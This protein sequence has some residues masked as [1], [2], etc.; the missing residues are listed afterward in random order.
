MKHAYTPLP[1]PGIDPE[2]DNEVKKYGLHPLPSRTHMCQ[3]LASCKR[4]VS[5]LE[6]GKAF[7]MKRHHYPVLK[8]R[9]QA[10]IR[11]EQI[12]GLGNRRYTINA[13]PHIDV[14]TLL[15]CIENAWGL[16]ETYCQDPTEQLH[17]LP[18]LSKRNSL[19]NNDFYK[20]PFVTID[21]ETA[22]DF[23]DAIYIEPLNDHGFI[24]YVAISNVSAAILPETNLNHL[25]RNRGS[26]IYFPIR[27]AYHMLPNRLA[28]ER[29]SLLP[30]KDR[31]CMIFVIRFEHFFSQPTL[32]MHLS[33]IKTTA[34]L[35][36]QQVN[37][38]LK[39]DTVPQ[40]FA[41]LKCFNEHFFQLS[42][43]QGV[44]D[45]SG[46]ELLFTTN[47]Q[48]ECHITSRS[49]GI[50]ERA[51]E[52]CM[53]MVN[54]LA[55]EHMERR[56]VVGL[57]RNH[58][59]PSIEQLQQLR[60][61][62]AH[63]GLTLSP[64]DALINASTYHQIVMMLHQTQRAHMIPAILRTLSGAFYAVGNQGHF[65]LHKKAYMH[66]TSPIRRY[67][68]LVAQRVLCQVIHSDELETAD[69][70][71]DVDVGAI[72]RYNTIAEELNG[73]E[74]RAVSSERNAVNALKC[75]TLKAAI[76]QRFEGVITT[77][78]NDGIMIGFGL[79]YNGF[80]AKQSFPAHVVLDRPHQ[81]LRHATGDVLYTVGQ[82][83][84]LELLYIDYYTGFIDVMVIL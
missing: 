17:C 72:L 21:S 48:G 32:E 73:H 14:H 11:D 60:A 57:F 9:L 82:Y 30:G 67:A 36:Y 71:Y 79:C 35:T 49:R 81:V 7:H 26:S 55:A 74:K 13:L 51:I 10:M 54:T 53:V 78:M 66:V 56:Q 69:A 59:S 84:T 31:P 1:I 22:K 70:S 25:A 65:G 58:P 46:P 40:E 80:A 52:S 34:R 39:N 29:L 41:F 2:Y 37:T 50:A 68:D 62:T 45:M 47:D 16:S 28:E 4:P 75:L 77:I 63:L 83:V 8:R 23:D 38:W 76:G 3:Y 42:S 24:I 5:L 33:C 19:I 44:F 6:L 18:Q 15:K 12:I 64:D 61:I 20:K 27:E 43:H